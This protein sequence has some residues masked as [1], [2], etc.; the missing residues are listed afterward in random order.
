ME[1]VYSCTD[2]L[3]QP[4]VNRKICASVERTRKGM[5]GEDCVCAC[6]MA[7]R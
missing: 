4:G 3:K 2:G 5:Y 7:V 1:L 6:D